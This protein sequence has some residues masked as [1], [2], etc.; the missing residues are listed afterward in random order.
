[1]IS[2]AYERLPTVDLEEGFI[3]KLRSVLEDMGIPTVE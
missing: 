3:D 1:V 2:L